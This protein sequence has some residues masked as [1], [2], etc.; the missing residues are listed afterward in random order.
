MNVLYLILLFT[1]IHL[2]GQSEIVIEI[3]DKISNENYEQAYSMIIDL[4]DSIEKQFWLGAL[5]VSRWNDLRIP[6]DKVKAVEIFDKIAIVK[7]DSLDKMGKYYVAQAI[8]QL[9][10]N[11]AQKG[12]WLDAV[13]QSWESVGLFEDIL[14]SDPKFIDAETGIAVF[15]YWVTDKLPLY[16]WFSL[17]FSTKSHAIEILEKVTREGILTATLA[18]QQLFWIYINEE[19]YDLA[20][21]ISIRFVAKNSNSRQVL[22]MNYFLAAYRENN[23]EAYEKLL[24]LESTYRELDLKSSINLAEILMKKFEYTYYLDKSDEALALIEDIKRLNFNDY[25][26]KFLQSKIDNYNKIKDE[27]LEN[28]NHVNKN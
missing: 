19:E 5:S 1:F 9:G 22:W 25:E 17:Q 2:P 10:I 3:S 15:R 26:Q 14:E 13:G 6:V 23:K 7:P 11:T 24:I 21:N 12:D 16:Y 27:F 20:E 4:P 28:I 18:L 8:G